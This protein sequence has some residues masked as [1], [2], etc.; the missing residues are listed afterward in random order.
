MKQFFFGLVVGGLV[1]VLPAQAADVAR[2]KAADAASSNTNKADSA[3]ATAADPSLSTNQTDSG[4]A[5]D[6]SLCL[7]SMETVPDDDDLV[8][9]PTAMDGGCSV[10]TDT[11]ST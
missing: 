10:S 2:E 6:P 9:T 8:P 5:T 3:P 11:I 1:A 4:P 7:D